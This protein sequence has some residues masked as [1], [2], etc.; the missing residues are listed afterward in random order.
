MPRIFGPKIVPSDDCGSTN[1]SSSD[2]N[3]DGGISTSLT[4][5]IQAFQKQFR[6]QSFLEK[7]DEHPAKSII[8]EQIK[9]GGPQD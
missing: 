6:G 2:H 4:K 8:Y 5:F 1:I 7:F 3:S 9:N